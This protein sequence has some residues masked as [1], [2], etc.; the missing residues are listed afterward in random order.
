VR[1][2]D[3]YLALGTYQGDN[4]PQLLLLLVLVHSTCCSL[5]EA[6]TSLSVQA[7]SASSTLMAP[8]SAAA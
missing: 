4:R 8:W 3:N 7:P 1:L 6:S 5:E 2:S